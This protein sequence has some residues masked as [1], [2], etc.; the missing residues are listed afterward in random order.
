[1]RF[2]TMWYMRPAKPQI[3]L[4]I[5]AVWSEPL[6]I[7]WI[8]YE[9]EA[10]DW[11]S[12]GVSTLKRRLHR[13]F[14]VYSC[15]KKTHCWKSHVAAHICLTCLYPWDLRWTGKWEK[16]TYQTTVWLCREM[17]RILQEHN[18]LFVPLLDSAVRP[19]CHQSDAAFQTS[20]RHHH[21][22]IWESGKQKYILCFNSCHRKANKLMCQS[23]AFFH[24]FL[25]LGLSK[26]VKTYCWLLIFISRLNT[27]SKSFQPKKLFFRI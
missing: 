26:K 2:P 17:G 3:I 12:F 9:C 23:D 7:V 25:L 18:N 14:W 15:K 8:F 10:T 27:S 1:M 4:R 6:L 5:R 11:T 16:L 19:R 24:Q 22:R 13:L 21:L 20:P